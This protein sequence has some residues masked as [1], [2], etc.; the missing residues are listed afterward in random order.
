MMN[1]YVMS[2]NIFEHKHKSSL[3]AREVF[4]SIARSNHNPIDKEFDSTK[5]FFPMKCNIQIA[6]DVSVK[7][8]FCIQA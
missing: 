3:I 2:L 1:V 6:Q 4:K 8:M 5:T 7:K